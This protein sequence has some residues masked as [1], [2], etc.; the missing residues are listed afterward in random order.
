VNQI[1][2]QSPHYIVQK[3]KRKNATQSPLVFQHL[4]KA[5]QFVE[6]IDLN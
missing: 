2:F 6:N 1:P 4:S 5:K 3:A